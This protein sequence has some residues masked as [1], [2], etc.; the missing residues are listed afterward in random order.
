MKRDHL[1]EKDFLTKLHELLVKSKKKGSNSVWITVKEVPQC[2][3]ASKST[4]VGSEDPRICLVR[5]K[6]DRS[7]GTVCVIESKL[8][9]F[10]SNL[11]RLVRF[12]TKTPEPHHHRNE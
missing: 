3:L 4:P 1:S 11:H 9:S 10:L 6:C 2:R 12:H 5:F 7:R 8:K